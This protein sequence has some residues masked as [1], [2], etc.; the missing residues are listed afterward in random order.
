MQTGYDTAK[1]YLNQGQNRFSQYVDRGNSASDMYSNSLGL[2]GQE[3]STAAQGAFEQSTPYQGMLGRAQDAL[4]RKRAAG[5]ML[6]SGNADADTVQLTRDYLS[7]LYQNWQ[8][9]L[10]GLGQQGFSATGAQA[11]FDQSLAG[12]SNDY[13]N[14]RANFMNKNVQ[15]TIGLGLGAMKAGD[16]AHTA[17]QNMLLG[18]INAGVGALGSIFGIPGVGSGVASGF[19]NIFGGGNDWYGNIGMGRG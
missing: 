9:N 18:G 10:G 8:Q 11:G 19:K 7:P 2:N 1:G 5:G 14:Q 12:L 15:D 6:N 13:Y 16:Q 17:N 4:F 3:G